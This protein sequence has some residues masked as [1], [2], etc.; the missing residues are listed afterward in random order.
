MVLGWLSSIKAYTDSNHPSR[1]AQLERMRTFEIP[2]WESHFQKVEALISEIKV[3]RK[4]I[5]V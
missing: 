4:S 3:D 1:L 5:N 2:T